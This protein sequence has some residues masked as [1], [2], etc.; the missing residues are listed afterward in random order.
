MADVK[1][2]LQNH[3]AIDTNQTLIV[4]FNGYGASSLDLFIYTFTKT[5]NWIQFHEIKQDILLK[6]VEIV[7]KHGAD[8]AFPTTTLD[9]LEVLRPEPG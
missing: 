7:H 8:F 5:T 2:M 3:E 1:A 4:N 9:G 6:I